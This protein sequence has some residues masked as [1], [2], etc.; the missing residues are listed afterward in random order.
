MGHGSNENAAS[1]THKA[2]RGPFL[3]AFF[4]VVLAAIDLQDVPL[5]WVAW[6]C[7][8]GRTRFQSSQLT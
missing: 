2:A 3:G 5:D 4:F 6:R 8:A 1:I 7:F